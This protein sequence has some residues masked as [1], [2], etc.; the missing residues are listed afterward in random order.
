MQKD[1]AWQFVGR[2]NLLFRGLLG[3]DPAD[4]LADAE[5]ERVESGRR[6]ISPSP[7]SRM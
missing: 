2:R 7:T 5:I 6:R 1:Q 4:V 3:N